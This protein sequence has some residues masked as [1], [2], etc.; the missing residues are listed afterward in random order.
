M[1]EFRQLQHS[2][3]R[4]LFSGCKL[5]QQTGRSYWWRKWYAGPCFWSYRDMCISFVN[6]KNLI[7]LSKLTG[8]HFRSRLGCQ[9]ITS[10]EL[11]GIHLALPAAIRNFVV[12]GYATKS[13]WLHQIMMGTSWV[14]YEIYLFLLLTM[15]Y[16]QY[17]FPHYFWFPCLI[18]MRWQNSQLGVTT[19]VKHIWKS[20]DYWSSEFF[21]IWKSYI[22]WSLL[23]YYR[24]GFQQ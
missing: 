17:Q 14:E 19:H 22:L 13:H 1:N 4:M 3:T 20:I 9:V 18:L 2:L 7:I 12:D 6:P 24:I 11:D 15:P 10:P 16:L 5:L 21:G 23:P 8:S